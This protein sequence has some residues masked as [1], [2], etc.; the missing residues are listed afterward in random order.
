M[1][2]SKASTGNMHVELTQVD[3]VVLGCTHYVFLRPVLA[4]LLPPNVQVLDGNEGTAR[5]LKRVLA[6]RELL[7]DGPGGVTLET[8]GDAAA[9]IPV[10]RRLLERA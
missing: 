3:A 8:S 2:M 7:A 6:A 4:E 10:M 1:E 5:Q 9:V